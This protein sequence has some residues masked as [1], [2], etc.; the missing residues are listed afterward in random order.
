MLNKIRL[1]IYLILGI[2]AIYCVYFF[3]ANPVRPTY[4]DCGEIMSK[5]SDEVAIKHGSRT[6]L[7]LNIQFR[8]SGFKSMEV[9]PT[10]YFKHKVGEVICFDLREEKGES[11]FITSMIGA[12]ILVVIGLI[13]LFFFLGFLIDPFMNGYN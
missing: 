4:N 1:I 8:K 10:T 5:S 3:L 9:S 6:E 13:A 11:Y 12:M 2:G 7:Y